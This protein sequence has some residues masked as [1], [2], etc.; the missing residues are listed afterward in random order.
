[1]ASKELPNQP[2]GPVAN[3]RVPNLLTGRDP[4]S[5]RTKLVPQGETRHEPGSPSSAA[6]VHPCK[7]RPTVKLVYDDTDNLLRPLAR[8]RLRTVRP[9]FVAM[10]TRKPWVRRRRRW[11]G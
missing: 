8:R 11:F 3:D 6:F 1:M 4:Q 9:F 2:F 10:R 5:G 7:F